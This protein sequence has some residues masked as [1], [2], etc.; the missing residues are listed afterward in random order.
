MVDYS[1][2]IVIDA[3]A[4]VFIATADLVVFDNIAFAAVANITSVVLL[5]IL[6]ARG[7]L[8]CNKQ[9]QILCC[10]ALFILLS[11]IVSFEIHHKVLILGSQNI[12][13]NFSGHAGDLFIVI[14]WTFFEALR[15]RD[16]RCYCN[17]C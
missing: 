13:V 6:I 17:V 8:R 9:A 2:V 1:F 11:V 10:C 16:D 12:P 15:N 3:V 4:I 5:I 7:T 14:P